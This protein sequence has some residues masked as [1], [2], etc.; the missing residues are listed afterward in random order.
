KENTLLSVLDKTVTPMGAR[1]F[2]RWLLRPLRDQSVLT[3]R[4][5]SIQQLIHL[6][7]SE[8]CKSLLKPLG[9]I[10]RVLARIALRTA[11]PRDFMQLRNT[12]SLLPGLHKQL[13]VF[14][15]AR[16]VQLDREMGTFPEL[17]ALLNR[18][19]IDEPP[20]LIRDGGVIAP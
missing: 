3:Q 19:L 14:E 4:Q 11:R 18:A 5:L 20:V 8:L 2:R 10:E 6:Q 12:L 13:A 9:D 7:G 15:S 17:L 16:L 1:L